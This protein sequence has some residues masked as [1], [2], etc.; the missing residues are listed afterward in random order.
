MD[1]SYNPGK[2]LM[3]GMLLYHLLHLNV[4]L[5]TARAAAEGH[6]IAVSGTSIIYGSQGRNDMWKN[7]KKK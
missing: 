5:G 1:V 7:L 6:A 2:S 3:C 4:G